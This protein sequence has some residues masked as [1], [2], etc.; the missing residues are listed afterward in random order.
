VL[1][2]AQSP[3]H[4]F[5]ISLGCAKNL[6][7]T[8]VMCGKLATEGFLLTD[9]P[10]TADI[11]I[12][13]TC[14]FIQEAR[15]EAES[16]IE[17]A[18]AWKRAAEDR[19]LVVTG[20]VPQRDPSSILEQYP[21]VDLFL[22]VDDIPDVPTHLTNLIQGRCK[23]QNRVRSKP[24]SYVYDHTVPRLQ[25]T[26]SSYA[27]LK[28]AEG[29]SHGCRFCSIPRIRGPR[30]SR[31]QT[32][33]VQEAKQLLSQG[34]RELN[35]IAQDT[36][37]YGKDLDNSGEDLPSLL[38]Q[39]D[40]LEGDFWV[41][42]LYTH[43]AYIGERLIQTFVDTDHLVPYID[44]PLQHINDQVLVTM[45]RRFDGTSTRRL[46]ESLRD[47]IP[48]LALRTTFL[49]GHPGETT[50]AFEE[51]YNFVAST[52]F[53]RLG[54]FTFSPEPGTPS[55][56]LRDEVVPPQTAEE[57]R[58]ALLSLQQ[59]I[60]L[61]HNRELLDTEVDVLAVSKHED[62]RYVGRTY[63]DAPEIDNFVYF[64]GDDHC[65][66]RGFNRVRIHTAY[67]YDL[68]GERRK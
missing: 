12:I 65:L 8:E 18:L 59:D 4:V 60:S 44:V 63:A 36:T 66:T 21:E 41:R 53:E 45:G 51:L 54:V 19:F 37:S 13:N 33:I 52:A 29:C 38:E 61:E 50:E 34:V 64:T 57:R 42:V 14:G 23:E 6:V 26:P 24:P 35:L 47:R 28:I 49:V 40:R 11:M 43:P 17:A 22:G 62:G 9:D 39:L 68:E 1:S 7:D 32:S 15:R 25:L 67:P 3:T 58:E 30:R 56:E 46:I 16:E 2:T 5:F 55:A 20:C 31:P 27:Y 10:E 48:E